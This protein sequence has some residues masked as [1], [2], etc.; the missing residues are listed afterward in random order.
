MRTDTKHKKVY[1][2][3]ILGAKLVCGNT[4]VMDGR[5][6]SANFEL[7]P[8]PACGMYVQ[9]TGTGPCTDKIQEYD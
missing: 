5:I 8:C 7:S 1:N 6:P 2:G 4:V 3:P 9:T